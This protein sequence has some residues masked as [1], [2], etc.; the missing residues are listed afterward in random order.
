[1]VLHFYLDLPLT[2]AAGILDI[3]VGTAKSRLHRGLEALRSAIGRRPSLTRRP[4]PGAVPMNTNDPFERMVAGYMANEGS[5]RRVGPGPGRR[6]RLDEPDAVIS[7]LARLMKEPPMRISSRVVVGSPTLRLAAIL[8]LTLALAL[9]LR[10]AVAGAASLL[11]GEPV[12]RPHSGPPATAPS[13]TPRTATSTS[14]TPDGTNDRAIIAGPGLTNGRGSGTRVI[15]CST[16]RTTTSAR[17]SGPRTRTAPILGCSS[18]TMWT[19]SSHCPD[20]TRPRLV[21]RRRHRDR[22][23]RPRHRR[24]RRRVRPRRTARSRARSGLDRRT[25]TS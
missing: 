5:A 12:R 2:E 14:P 10:A 16:S 17:R 7:A 9:A 13:P 19:S 15:D 22:D 6:S 24:C 18:A 23:H 8:A 20:A 1:M 11:P 4:G 25:G 21:R 3:P